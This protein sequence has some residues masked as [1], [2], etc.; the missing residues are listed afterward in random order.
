[1]KIKILL[2]LIATLFIF[3]EKAHTQ[4]SATFL[5]EKAQIQAKK[6]GKAIFVKFE[7]SWCSWCHRMTKNMKEEST[8]TFFESNYVSV[9]IVVFERSNKKE[10]ENE[11]GKELIE[12]Y[13][14][15]KSKVGL[16]FWFILDSDLNLIADSYD[17]KK[18]NLGCPATKEEV[19]LFIEKLKGTVKKVTK[20]DIK[21]ITKEFVLK[22]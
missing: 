12:K 2:S 14:N 4:E 3:T 15:G 20:K 11:G 8:K 7:A 6:E 10:L 13:N 16:P 17:A 1:M 19:A 5:L 9:P 21:A 18:Q 22:K